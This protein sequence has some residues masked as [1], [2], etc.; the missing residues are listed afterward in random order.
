VDQEQ[1]QQMPAE[2]FNK[3]FNIGFHQAVQELED[4]KQ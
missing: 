1:L 4:L 3:Q 2:F